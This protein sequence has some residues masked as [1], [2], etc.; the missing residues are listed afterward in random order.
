MT[1]RPAEL[2]ITGWHGTIWQP[3][4]VVGETPKRYRIRSRDE[5]PVR[6]AGRLRY[7]T[8]KTTALVPKRAVRMVQP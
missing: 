1:E 2:G 6:L 8:D 5:N 7:V 4:V 3:V